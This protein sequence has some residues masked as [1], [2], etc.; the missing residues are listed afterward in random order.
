MHARTRCQE[1]RMTPA[2]KKTPKTL[3]PEAF[4]I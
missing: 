2:K 1:L 4:G 3:P